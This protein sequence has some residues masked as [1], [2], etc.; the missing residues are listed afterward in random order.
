MQRRYW[1]TYRGMIGGEVAT[2]TVL[3][4][5]F[6]TQEYANEVAK[7]R[8]G[9]F[10]VLKVRGETKFDAVQH[11]VIRF[12]IRTLRI[13]TGAAVALLCYAF[14]MEPIPNI[15]EVPL[16]SLTLG[17]IIGAVV[18]FGIGMAITC[19]AWFTAF[20]EAPKEA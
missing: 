5:R 3:L 1:I 11:A 16:A 17:D 20:G 4:G 2:K 7:A 13:A 12:I 9:Y 10:D 18:R 8:F 6:D 14:I 19:G 15:F